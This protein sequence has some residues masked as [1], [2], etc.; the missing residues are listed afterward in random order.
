MRICSVDIGTN[1]FILLI[2]D[3]IDGK[4]FPIHQEFAIPRLGEDI[5]TNK[6]IK[7]DAIERSVAVLEKFSEIIIRFKVEKVIPIATAV[8][9]DAKNSEEVRTQ[10]SSALGYEIKVITGEEEA[11]YSFMGV[12]SNSSQNRNK[13]TT[14]D[15][16]G[17]STEIIT[18]SL[19]GIN[20]STSIQVGAA[21]IRDLFFED[22]IYSEEKIQK[23]KEYISHFLE[24]LK[25]E[26][27][28]IDKIVGVGGTITTLAF[29]KS[30]L[31]KYEPEI[32]DKLNLDFSSIKLIFEQLSK[33]TPEEIANRY[34]IHPK[35]ADILLP[36]QLILISIME[37]L[38]I[39]SI[40]VS[41]R[42][43]RYGVI[44]DY[45]NKG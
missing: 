17:G 6:F 19:S 14:I 21:K 41:S 45:L 2:A 33:L 15:I 27:F 24:N 38:G 13:F 3:L 39:E 30:G 10:L 36:G 22:N 32:I 12:I 23:A 11:Y 35:R 34:K 5:V 28:E 40:H 8:L 29:I 44:Q 7:Q 31:D 20:Y 16:G 42:G 18:G 43:L 26:K 37:I 1:S 9:R 25:D 4:I